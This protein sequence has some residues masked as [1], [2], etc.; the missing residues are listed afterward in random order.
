MQA[1]DIMTRDVAV[2]SPETPTAEIARLLVERGIS[3]V[4]VLDNAGMAIGMV[5]EGDLVG[6]NDADREARRDWWLSLIAE[7]ES[8]HP[9]FLATLRRPELTAREVMSAPVILITETADVAEI[10]HLLATYRIKRVPVVRD[11]RVVGIVS[12]ADVLRALAT[13]QQTE[14]RP[15][16]VSRAR[17]LLTEA[18]AAIDQHFLSHRHPTQDGTASALRGST[19]HH[20]SATDFKELVAEF[21]HHKAESRDEAS[22]VQTVQHR[23]RVEE[24]IDHHISDENWNTIM[25]QARQA[26]EHGNK[27]FMLLR[28]PSELCTDRGRAINV[29]LPNWQ[30]TLRGEAAEIYRRWETDLKSKGFHITA[31]VL[32]FPDGMPGDIG[33]FLG[34][35]Q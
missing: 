10:A 3:A 27:Q 9:D 28:F 13:E 7:G 29:P 4:P 19:E 32:D 34:S 25:H 20:F 11:G 23:Q 14:G 15:N 35:E 26:A 21:E 18:L 5:S 33:L 24:L 22:L 2:V 8:L 6:R 12:R 17:G 1:S 30:N 16:H 31:R